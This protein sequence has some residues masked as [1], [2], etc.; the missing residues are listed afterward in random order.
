VGHSKCLRWPHLARVGQASHLWMNSSVQLLHCTVVVQPVFLFTYRFHHRKISGT[1]TT[2]NRTVSP[3]W[4]QWL[5]SIKIKARL[6]QHGARATNFATSFQSSHPR[7]TRFSAG[8]ISFALFRQISSKVSSN[9][10]YKV[11]S[12]IPNFTK[13]KYNHPVTS[14]K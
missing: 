9:F 5:K 2:V 10:P 14:P 1:K 11:Y 7:L 12:N 13:I 8:A 4:L 6:T 3:T